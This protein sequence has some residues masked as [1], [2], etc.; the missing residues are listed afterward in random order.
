MDDINR[1]KKL[2]GLNE[3]VY[4]DEA[5]QAIEKLTRK[6]DRIPDDLMYFAAN[7]DQSQ[8]NRDIIESVAKS[9][10]NAAARIRS[11]S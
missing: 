8:D 5:A 6:I 10:E 3:S 11:N 7:L 1:L 9:L 4:A 2:S